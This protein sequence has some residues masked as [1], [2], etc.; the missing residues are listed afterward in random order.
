MLAQRTAHTWDIPFSD[1]LWA[2]QRSEETVFASP[3]V[4]SK[5]TGIQLSVK[6][7]A[8]R[9]HKRYVYL[10]LSTC[11][12]KVVLPSSGQERVEICKERDLKVRSL[13]VKQTWPNGS[14]LL[15]QDSDTIIGSGEYGASTMYALTSSS[16]LGLRESQQL[17][18]GCMRL[19]ATITY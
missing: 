15:M 10:Y 12:F 7:S 13:A 18:N 3:P 1:L 8:S 2:L 14:N 19:Q 16:I 9:S 17:V 4:Y 11:S 5:S 6:M